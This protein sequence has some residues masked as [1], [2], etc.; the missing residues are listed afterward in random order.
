MFDAI[1]SQFEPLTKN[2][3]F[4]NLDKVKVTRFNKTTFVLSGSF[5]LGLDSLEGL[6][7]SSVLLPVKQ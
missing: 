5:D 3:A 2:N 4:L 6:D 1:L 7:V